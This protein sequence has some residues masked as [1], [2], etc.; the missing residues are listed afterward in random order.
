LVT[1]EDAGAYI[2]RL[3]KKDYDSATWQTAMQVLI[4]AADHDGSIDAARLGMMQA[5]YPVGTPVYRYVDKA[6]E[7]RNSRDGRIDVY[8]TRN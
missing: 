6:Q 3:P 2:S 5:L 1:L 8:P 4:A 7:G